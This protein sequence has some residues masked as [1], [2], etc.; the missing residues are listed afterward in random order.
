[1]THV[2][3]F[4]AYTARAVILPLSKDNSVVLFSPSCTYMYSF[5][6]I[7]RRG[8]ISDTNWQNSELNNELDN[9]DNKVTRGE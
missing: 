9:L 8:Y 3:F 2:V 1:M 6:K 7:E 4:T 5:V